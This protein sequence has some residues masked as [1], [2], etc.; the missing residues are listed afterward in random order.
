MS[1][2][3]KK[4]RL[5][6]YRK[7]TEA[8]WGEHI[9]IDPHFFERNKEAIKAVV[10]S[11][12]GT[13]L[14]KE[15]TQITLSLRIFTADGIDITDIL[16]RGNL[17][18]RWE[19]VEKEFG[20]SQ[21]KIVGSSFRLNY[22]IAPRTVQSDLTASFSEEEALRLL[23]PSSSVPG[24][25]RYPSDFV[26]NL[27]QLKE[28]KRIEGKITLS[29]DFW[30]ELNKTNNTVTRVDEETSQLK[31]KTLENQREL[32]LNQI[33][34]DV[35][36]IEGSM[37][38]KNNQG[39]VTLEARVYFKEQDITEELRARGITFEWIRKNPEGV[40]E[41]GR[42]DSSWIEAHRGRYQVTLTAAD[43]AGR[44]E[45]G[46]SVLNKEVIERWLEE[47]HLTNP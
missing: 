12:R 18:I 33:S 31:S 34:L 30:I 20:R 10:E 24:S 3:L 44:A 14:S 35:K 2:V 16:Q 13:V 32:L 7:P 46:C 38:F 4:G 17:A 43:N 8:W 41:N 36:V 19:A 45:I 5:E 29:R 23:F 21:S 1:I 40:D 27:I 37:I 47:N 22:V 42:T 28:T 15:L 11:E 25:T 6:R 39:R 26:S 9:D